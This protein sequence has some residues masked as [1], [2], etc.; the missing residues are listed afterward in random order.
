MAEP[1]VTPE[2]LIREAL[3]NWPQFESDAEVN[4]G[5]M[6]EWFGEWRER[7]QSFGHSIVTDQPVT[8]PEL[9]AEFLVRFTDAEWVGYYM[10][11]RPLRDDGTPTDEP[12]VEVSCMESR[13]DLATINSALGT[14]F[15]MSFFPGR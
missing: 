6:V 7:C 4:G 1:N 3:F 15:P 8:I 14:D 2:E 5:D 12:W 10:E 13:D 9:G 11:T